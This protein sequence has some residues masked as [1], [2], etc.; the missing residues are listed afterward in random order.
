[1]SSSSLLPFLLCLI[2][3]LNLRRTLRSEQKMGRW[4][5]PFSWAMGGIIVLLAVE[6][7]FKVQAV[8]MW[9]WHVFMM[10][11]LYKLHT[12]PDFRSRKQLALAFLP[13]VIVGMVSDFIESAFND[14][15]ED[16]AENYLETA[17]LLAVVWLIAMWVTHNKQQKTLARE[18]EKR[19]LETEMNKAIAA[20]K[21]ELESEVAERTTELIKQKEELE[22]AL[23]ELKATQDQLIQQEKLAS[24][25]ELTAGIAHEIQNPLN[26]VNNFAEVSI[27]LL[28]ELET[29]IEKNDLE[30]VNA[31]AAD[32]RQNL[33]KISEHGRRADGIVKGMLQHSRKSTGQKETTDINAL[34]DE[35]LRLSYHGLRAK[36]K[37]FNANLK[38]EFSESLPSVQTVPQELGR[39]MLNMFNNSFYS[40]L[41]KKK[42]QLDNYEPTVSIRTEQIITEEGKPAVQVTIRDNGLGIPR[43]VL[44]KIYQPFFTTKPAGEGTGLGLSLSYDI[45]TKVHGGELRVNTA[46]GEFAEFVIILPI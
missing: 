24:L 21:V 12:E 34:A 6:M 43:K 22:V 38:T 40:V 15:Y 28:E 31:I 36:D 35:Y 1:M 9:I 44:D 32:I 14:F 26:F 25:G 19:R 30:D 41:Q 8:S 27:E 39:V 42:Q 13:Y 33:R 20:R 10:G 18:R 3:L 37:S 29:G 2:L 16:T 46:E 23:T 11:L 7:I 4:E 5:K 17:V 45:I